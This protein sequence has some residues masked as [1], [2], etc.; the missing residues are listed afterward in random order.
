MMIDTIPA[1]ESA[2]GPAYMIPSIPINSGMIKSK[3]KRKKIC[4][5][6]DKKVPRF[7]FPIDVKKFE[8]I[9]CIKLIKVQ[10]RKM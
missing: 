5:V 6:R 3:G 10:N 9:G 8:L 4:L 7:G 1:R 2:I